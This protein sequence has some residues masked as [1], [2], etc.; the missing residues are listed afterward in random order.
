MRFTEQIV[1][2]R[3]QTYANIVI[4]GVACAGSLSLI[5]VNRLLFDLN[6]HIYIL[7]FLF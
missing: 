5:D 6:T 2:C 3:G 7:A 4:I 1:C